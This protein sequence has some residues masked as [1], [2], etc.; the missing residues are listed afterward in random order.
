MRTAESVVLTDWPPG[1]LDAVDVDA[2]LV[3]LDLDLDVLDLGQHGDGRG[4]GVDAAL[5]LGGR[6]SLHAMHAGLELHLRE[7]LVAAD[8]EGDLLEAAR[9]ALA[10]VDLVDLP[11]LQLGVARV[12]AVQVARED[13]RLVT[14]GARP[15]LDDDVLVVVRVAR[16][17]HDLE[18]VLEHREPGL[19]LLDLL[20]GELPHL[21]VALLLEQLPGL[22]QLLRRRQVLARLLGE[23][24][25]GTLLLG[26]P[27]VLRL[28]G[29]DRRIAELGGQLGVGVE[30]VLKL[31]A[32]EGNASLRRWC[33]QTESLALGR[34]RAWTPRAA[35]TVGRRY[36]AARE[37]SATSCDSVT[38]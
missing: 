31:A 10:R 4:R 30:H 32:H 12:H 9:V 6:N 17:E 27:R 11:L 18:L 15:D 7:H 20:G 28:V 37:S 34:V 23:L 2:D 13:R 29:E 3:L 24:C 5:R 35:A 14:A 19:E 8:A 21:G 36:L 16:E 1:P 22:V 25:L 38:G 26:Q 33:L